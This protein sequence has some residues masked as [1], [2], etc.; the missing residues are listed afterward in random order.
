MR[1]IVALALSRNGRGA[2]MNGSVEKHWSVG[3][4]SQVAD[5]VV[6]PQSLSAPFLSEL[7]SGVASKKAEH[8]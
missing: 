3:W 8:E 7:Q 1:L 2:A 5:V 6:D 4:N